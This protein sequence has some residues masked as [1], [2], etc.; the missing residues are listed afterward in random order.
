MRRPAS[1]TVRTHFWTHTHSAKKGKHCVSLPPI[2]GP[3]TLKSQVQSF[4][5]ITTK[6]TWSAT[7]WF[8]WP[9]WPWCSSPCCWWRRRRLATTRTPA[10]P[11]ASS[12]APTATAITASA[13]RAGFTAVTESTAT[14]RIII[15][16]LC[17]Y[18]CTRIS[19]H[20]AWKWNSTKWQWK[21][22]IQLRLHTCLAFSSRR[23]SWLLRYF[24]TN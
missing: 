15:L 17:L 21:F 2:K 4:S 7:L 12:R 3:L 6:Q 1:C 24:C 8:S 9:P 5:H 14:V 20:F 11:P 19:D 13:R 22:A 16:V 18:K 23:Q 10:A